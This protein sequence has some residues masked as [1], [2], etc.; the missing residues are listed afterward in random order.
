M[1]TRYMPPR[2]EVKQRIQYLMEHG[3]LYP[4]EKEA[5]DRWARW[6]VVLS[7]AATAVSVLQLV[8][9]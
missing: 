4:V 7:A 5:T 2:D 8:M 1:R 6:A 9:N 3:G